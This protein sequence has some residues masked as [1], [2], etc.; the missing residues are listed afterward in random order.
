MRFWLGGY[1]ADM[2]GDGAG[3]GVLLAGDADA[4]S[5]G[6][7]LSFAGTA[8]AVDSPSW[9]AQHPTL[10]VVYAALEG[11]GGVRAFTRTGPATLAPIGTEQPAGDVTCH[12]VAS[13]DGRW[14]TA[15][16]YGDGTVARYR[17]DDDGVP[18]APEFG[19][20]AVDPYADSR[21]PRL[22][23][24][25]GA[26]A[27]TAAELAA[28]TAALRGAVG[29]EFAHLLPEQPVLP[30]GIE[31]AVTFTDPDPVAPPRTSHAHQARHVS[32]G[33]VATTDLGFDL[34]R[35]WRDGQLQ[36][37]VVLPFGTGPRHTVWHP[38]GHLYVVTE[39]S[40]EVYVLA[41]DATG[42]WRIVSAAPVSPEASVGADF[43]GELSA[44]ADAGLLYAGVRGIN[45]IAALRVLGDGSR[46][47]SIATVE[48]HVD[49]PRHHIL[50]SDTLLVAGQR[51]NEVVSLAIDERS[52]I[53]G[54][55]R[56]STPAPTPSVLLPIFD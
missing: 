38:S 22:P 15:T 12:V 30:E 46:V 27:T 10:D 2:D 28:A 33:L 3:I 36:Q 49:W 1:T 5:A 6:G 11:S 37:E 35:L 23:D 54:R 41:P 56:F 43:P 20:A 32:G 34:V 29:D 39:Y 14:L 45:A 47:E 31:S 42:R 26:D 13:P 44:S 8:V 40:C 25:L 55:R 48:S 52:G 16:G 9:L 4:P 50:V 7:P 24:D 51:S 53:P 19:A 17:L 21:A 18:G